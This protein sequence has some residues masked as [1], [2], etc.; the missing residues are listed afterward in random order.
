M[1]W[2]E[3]ISAILKL[4]EDEKAKLGQDIIKVYDRIMS[5]QEFMKKWGLD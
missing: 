5:P 3:D 4:R 1:D 2:L